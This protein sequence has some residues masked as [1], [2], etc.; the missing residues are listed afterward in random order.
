MFQLSFITAV[1]N[2]RPRKHK[3][4]TAGKMKILKEILCQLVYFLKKHWILTEKKS[5][6][7]N[8]A[9]GT[10]L[11]VSRCPRDTLSLR[12]LLYN[13][14]VSLYWRLFLQS[15]DQKKTS[16]IWAGYLRLSMFIKAEEKC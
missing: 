12:P 14:K 13:I 2:T 10:L 6:F 3:Q 1:S 5:P 11:L 7:F 4:Q 9:R 16:N 8:S 15:F